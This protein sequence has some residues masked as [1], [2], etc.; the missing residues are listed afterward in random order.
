MRSLSRAATALGLIGL[1]AAAFA[2]AVIGVRAGANASEPAV[3]V[4]RVVDPVLSAGPP[5]HAR[6]SAGGFTGFGAAALAGEVIAGGSLVAVEA[7]DQGGGTLVF[8]DGARETSVRYLDATRLRELVS[9]ADLSEGA[10][11]VLR[12]EDGDVVSLLHIPPLPPPEDAEADALQPERA[13]E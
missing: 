6:R 9:G 4:L 8:R 10:T 5:E 7:N 13:S 12:L 1:V 3:S 11:V 2:G